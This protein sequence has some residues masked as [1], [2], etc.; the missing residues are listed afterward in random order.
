M[1]RF[2]RESRLNITGAPPCLP[3]LLPQ[4]PLSSRF[5]TLEIEGEVS[6]EDLPRREPKARQSPPCLE[7]A[8]V[9]RERKVVVVGDSLVRGTEGPMCR[10][11]PSRREVCCPP[12]AWVRYIT[13]NN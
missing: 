5:E 1:R 6:G 10:P 7:T 2:G 13:R 9:R 4:L 3:T 11:D 8:S 12:G